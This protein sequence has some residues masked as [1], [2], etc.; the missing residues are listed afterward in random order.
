LKARRTGAQTKVAFVYPNSRIGLAADVASGT[1]ADSFLLGQNHLRNF[2]FEAY[3][4]EPRLNAPGETGIVHRVRWNLREALIPWEL[5]DAD[6][7]VSTLAN[8]LPASAKL[9]RRPHTVILDFALST[10]L[11]R[12]RGLMRHVFR[13]S[14]ESAAAIVCLSTTQRVRLL[15][16]VA[17]D[18]AR[19]HVVPLGIDHEF[20]RP[21]DQYQS[22]DPFVLA[23]GKDL[24][25]DYQTL[26][27]AA[28]TMDVRFIVVTEPR[29]T[30]GVAFP[31]NVQIRSGMS[32]SQL[33]DLYASAAC[34][35]LPLRRADYLYGT[36]SSGLTALMEGM[37][38][39]RPLV[40][41]DRPIIHEYV[42]DSD[43]ALVVP[44]EE[45]EVLAAAID[46]ILAEPELACRLGIAARASIERRHTMSQF[47][48]G[49]AGVFAQVAGLET[50][51][52]ASTTCRA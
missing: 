51:E 24:A 1:G 44:A 14:L 34:V 33:R 21:R 15:E 31:A 16:R 46:R 13:S 38:M 49:L 12:R 30:R 35:V 2:G 47:A 23:V 7:V 10:L 36:E 52:L 27:N 32:Y 8:L 9:R 6:I 22:A 48:A 5:E 40:A 41:S 4:H 42:T 28:A 17:L 45:P 25:R 19:V 29:N 26:A 11:D 37:A 18:P 39:A 43:T 50:Q 3:I 20:L